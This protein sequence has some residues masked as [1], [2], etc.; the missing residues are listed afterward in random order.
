M[1]SSLMSRR[2]V[3]KAPF[4]QPIARKCLQSEVV[5]YQLNHSP[6][7]RSFSSRPPPPRL[8][9]PPG[10]DSIAQRAVRGDQD[11]VRP[12][13]VTL[14][15]GDFSDDSDS[16]FD[17][18]EAYGGER[19]NAASAADDDDKTAKIMEELKF[20][21]QQAAAKKQRWLDNNE[22]PVRVSEIDE[23]GRAYG[24]GGRKTASARVWIQ[25]GFG[26]V[27]VN[28]RPFVEYFARQS[29]RDLILEPLVVTETC[30]K[31]DVTIMVQ[32]G[33][34]T[35]QAGAA[36]HGVANALNHYNPD[37]YR[38]PLKRMGFLTR[39]ARMVERKV[40]GRV[41]ARKSPQWVRR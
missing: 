26:Q 18:E 29:D 11:N 33:G 32:S 31:F 2:L 4:A 20:L 8:R 39:D 19:K 10:F 1:A 25:P 12:H 24:R 40:V 27:L 34:L 37:L 9:F 16:I 22:P 36:R 15:P 38:Y 17:T 13:V 30:G 3:A 6:L 23:R 35:G 7:A 14:F 28:K 21:E 5:N 41:K